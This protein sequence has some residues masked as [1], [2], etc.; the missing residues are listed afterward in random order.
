SWRLARSAGIGLR[1]RLGLGGRERW[2]RLGRPR[3]LHGGDHRRE[4]A[5]EHGA[6][7]LLAQRVAERAERQ[8]AA[9]A[10]GDPL[11][12]LANR[13]VDRLGR[14]LALPRLD[15]PRTSRRCKCRESPHRVVHDRITLRRLELDAGAASFREQDL[16]AG[17][18]G[19]ELRHLLVPELRQRG[20]PRR[21]EA[22]DALLPVLGGAEL[23]ALVRDQGPGS[24][25]AAQL[26]VGL[27][28]ELAG[29]LVRVLLDLD[30]ERLGQVPDVGLFR[31]ERGVALGLYPEALLDLLE[32]RELALLDLDD[33]EAERRLDDIAHLAHVEREGRL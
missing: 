14:G 1:L 4:R 25:P 8:R 31:F 23:A 17:Q 15:V 2:R 33:V 32:V 13:A 22:P 28:G 26:R 30:G 9:L 18:R 19:Q 10:L 29:D 24:G 21:V 20:A 3:G 12:E 7:V 5:L 16:E 6:A 11:E 27:A